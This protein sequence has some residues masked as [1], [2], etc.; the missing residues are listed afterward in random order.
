MGHF[1]IEKPVRKITF[2]NQ[3]A[4]VFY[5][6]DKPL[7]RNLAAYAYPID[8]Y[9][10]H[11]G[12]HLNPTDI[13]EVRKQLGLPDCEIFIDKQKALGGSGN[14]TDEWQSLFMGNLMHLMK[15]DGIVLK[16]VDEKGNNIL[17]KYFFP[18]S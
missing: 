3:N 8:E 9:C 6:K 7:T 10:R 5:E 4:V 17:V 18:K 13:E 14:L 11:I 16:K 1:D 12:Y 2:P 15:N